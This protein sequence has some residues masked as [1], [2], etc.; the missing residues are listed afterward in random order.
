MLK[1]NVKTSP[2]VNYFRILNEFFIYLHNQNSSIVNDG[3]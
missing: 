3:L 1:K 2:N